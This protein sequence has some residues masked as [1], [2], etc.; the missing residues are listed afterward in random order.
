MKGDADFLKGTFALNF[1]VGVPLRKSPFQSR[2]DSAKRCSP[3]M[4]VMT[5][6][7]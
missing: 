3:F 4:S 1:K 5:T 6:E 7:R 2:G